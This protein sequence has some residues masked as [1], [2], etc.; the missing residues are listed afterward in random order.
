MVAVRVVEVTLDNVVHVVS[1]GNRLVP[2]SS[3]VLV[4]RAVGAAVMIGSAR[5]RIPSAH[6]QPVVVDVSLVRMMQVALVKVIRM[7][8]VFDGRVSAV[9]PVLMCVR[10][11]DFMLHTS[12]LRPGG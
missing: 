3:A 4:I 2:T 7:T 9:G 12:L 1:V 6:F 10:V 11:D 8:V 5:A